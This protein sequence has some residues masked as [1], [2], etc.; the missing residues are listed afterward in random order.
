MYEEMQTHGLLFFLDIDNKALR[1]SSPKDR[2]P[3]RE[4]RL[5]NG[6]RLSS[7]ANLRLLCP[8]HKGLQGSMAEWYSPDFLKEKILHL[9]SLLKSWH[10]PPSKTHEKVKPRYSRH[11]PK[12]TLRLSQTDSQTSFHICL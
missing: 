7:N 8:S 3:G 1:R 12:D 4:L 11:T 5:L 2:L 9:V 6:D 10:I